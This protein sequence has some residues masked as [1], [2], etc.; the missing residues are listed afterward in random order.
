MHVVY[1]IDRLGSGGAQRQVVELAISMARADGVSVTLVAYP[2]PNFF[3]ERLRVSGVRV[4]EIAKSSKL[5]LPFPL[6]LRRWIATNQVDVVHAFLLG[7]VL[8][9]SIAVRL[10]GAQAQ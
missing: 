7:P 4:V 1:A 5:D 3:A 6:R 10:V 2:H 9:S 8:W